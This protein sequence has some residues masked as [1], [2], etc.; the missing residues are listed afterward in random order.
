M[1]QYTDVVERHRVILEAERWAKGIK[2]IHAHSLTSLWYETNPDRTGDDLM[3]CDTEYNDG[4][5]EREYIKT[6]KI[7]SIGEHLTGQAL[8]DEYGRHNR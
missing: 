5:I 7:E 6:G 2:G 4:V 1:G 8:Y 3:V